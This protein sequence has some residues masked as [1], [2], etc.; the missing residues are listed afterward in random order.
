MGNKSDK[1]PCQHMF[2]NGT[3]YE[4]FLETQCFKCT[5][6]RN[7][8]CR[9]VNACE[10]ARFLGEKVFPFDDLM[11]WSGGYGGKTCKSYTTTPIPRKQ[12]HRKAIVGQITIS[13][14]NKD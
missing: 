14:V 9:I 1:I 2:S 13:E 4:L 11:D 6:F 10:R 8:H 5:R 7:W 3:E 12:P